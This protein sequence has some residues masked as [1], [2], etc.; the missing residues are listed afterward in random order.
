MPKKEINQEILKLE[1]SDILTF[2]ELDI[3]EGG[4]F[5]FHSGEN[6]LKKDL[7]FGGEKYH[8]MPIAAEGFELKG[9]GRLPR[10]KLRISNVNGLMS[11]R[12]NANNDFTG[13][14]LIRKRTFVKF[15]DKENFPEDF[16][17]HGEPDAS[18][19]LPRDEFIVN[20]K[21]LE[22]NQVIEYE[23]RSVLDLENAF[24]PGRR[25][26]ADYCCWTY[27][28][29]VG[30]KYSGAAIADESDVSF[31]GGYLREMNLSDK[32]FWN[33]D[34]YY[35]RGDWV[36]IPKS[37]GQAEH[38]PLLVFVCMSAG[39]VR[40]NPLK[41]KKNWIQDQC[42][43][44]LDGCRIRFGNLGEDRKEFFSLE[45]DFDTNEITVDEQELNQKLTLGDGLPYGGFPGTD[46]FSF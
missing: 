2:Y 37:D 12:S 21:T 7:I 22:N 15:L 25:I 6:G 4:S 23:L 24:L 19:L 18:A 31:E 40:S 29:N 17:P 33:P 16:N 44:T 28:S 43:K 20:I 26:L 35:S 39:G 36:K 1:P 32:G 10:P 38:K 41:D 3:L 46:R 8:P 45:I 11:L 5:Y 14:K 9:D 30:C 27:R 34:F 13:S 42:S